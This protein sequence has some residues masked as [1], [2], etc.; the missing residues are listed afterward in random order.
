MSAN[1]NVSR[2]GFIS[3]AASGAGA[4]ALGGLGGPSVAE[5]AVPQRWDKEVDV[6]VVGYGGAGAAAAITA[7]DAGAKVVILE[8]TSQ[9]GGSTYYSGGFYVSPKDVSGAVDYLMQCARAADGRFFD[10]DRDD[11]TAWAEEAVQNE[12]WIRSLGGESFVSLKG[13]YDAKGADS[14][15]SWQTKPDA[16]GVALWQILSDA[17]SKRGIE[18]LTNAEGQELVTREVS[19]HEGH[20][21]VEVL[22]IITSTSGDR[23]IKAKKGI[24]L[25]CGGFDYNETMK[26]SYLRQYPSFST[27]H[28]GNTGD[29]IR[30]AAK[31]GAAL[32]HLTGSAS[33]LCHKLPDVPVAFPSQLQLNAASLS[34]VFVNRLGKR[35]T[36]EELNYD[37]VA[38]TLS[39]FDAVN[40]EFQNIP[41]W[42]IFDEKTRVKGPAG[43]PVPIG[44]PIYTWNSDNSEEI[45]KGW[46]IK[47][48]TLTELA[49]KIGIDAAALEKTIATYNNYC[50]EGN[51]P[52]FGRKKGLI[53]L[54]RPPYHA[55]KGYPGLWATGGGPRMNAK[56]QVLDVSGRTIR[57]LYVA[58]SASSFC[59]SYLYPLSGTAIGDCFA[60]GR[61]AGRNANAENTW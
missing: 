9:G 37:A 49:A 40:R 20:P 10:L 27:G 12:L 19:D 5:A 53:A 31:T 25:T 35:F 4:T 61:I 30:L 41:C 44:K 45:T 15:T 34:V 16:T 51:D 48:D 22:G 50:A 29:A 14:Y 2:R 1:K 60:M 11:L 23:Q 32:W 59:F 6:V 39:N 18:I 52:D 47:A 24:I 46:I 43:L 54:D 13:W 57:R 56:A 17:V 58:G 42:C 38:K 26:M 3:V 7:H 21:G 33:N 28:P 8:K 55:L 36:N